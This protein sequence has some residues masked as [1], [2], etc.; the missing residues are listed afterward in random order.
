MRVDGEPIAKAAEAALE[1]HLAAC[2][3]CLQGLQTEVNRARA[4]EAALTALK[5]NPEFAGEVARAA[6]AGILAGGARPARSWMA[7]RILY[8]LAPLALAAA[9]AAGIW[10]YMRI[11][12]TPP[13]EASGRYVLEENFQDH[14]IVPSQ[15]GDP[16]GRDVSKTHWIY[17]IPTPGTDQDPAVQLKLDVERVDTNYIKLTNWNY[18]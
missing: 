1:S 7:P 5:V 2:P 11:P 9:A 8:G 3:S 10:F 4:L 18:H 13:A 16:L 15:E 17:V 14:D 12:P 6:L